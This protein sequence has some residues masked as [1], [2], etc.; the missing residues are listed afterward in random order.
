MDIQGYGSPITLDTSNI[1]TPAID[2]DLEAVAE[3]ESDDDN[4][5]DSVGT[6]ENEVHAAPLQGWLCYPV[7]SSHSLASLVPKLSPS[8]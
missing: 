8:L 5:D 7:T 6:T 2:E 3:D 1:L 4:E